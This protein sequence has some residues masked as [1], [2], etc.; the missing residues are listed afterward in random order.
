MENPSLGN[1]D[2][3]G[4]VPDISRQLL[5]DLHAVGESDRRH[6]SDRTQ[7]GERT[8]VKTP[9]SPETHTPLVESDARKDRDD[10]KTELVGTRPG[11]GVVRPV[12]DRYPYPTGSVR[13]P[14]GGEHVYVR[15]NPLGIQS[16]GLN[17]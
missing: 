3:D 12:G 6:G 17:F 1:H 14:R 9:T 2:I 7:V 11:C 8:I 4:L 13:R 16:L 15:P 5:Y 10:G